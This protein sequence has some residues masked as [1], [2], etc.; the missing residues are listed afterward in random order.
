MSNI[1]LISLRTDGPDR[2][3]RTGR[4]DGM[5]GRAGRVAQTDR[6]VL[7]FYWGGEIQ[8]CG[9]TITRENHI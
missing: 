8:F 4:T 2:T 5:D 9:S 6:T 1:C 7:Q 3:G